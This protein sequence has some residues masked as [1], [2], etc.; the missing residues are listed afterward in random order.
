MTNHIK[1]ALL[2]LLLSFSFASKGQQFVV[3]ESS[4][5]P[6]S[7]GQILNETAL[8]MLD[9]NNELTVISEHGKLIKI[10]GPYKGIIGKEI[11]LNDEK[12]T[13]NKLTTLIDSLSMLLMKNQ[14]ERL[15]A[16]RSL[17]VTFTK[18]KVINAQKKAWA[19]D[20]N[21]S[22]NQCSSSNKTLLWNSNKAASVF[23]K[24]KSE[25]TM[26]TVDLKINDLYS[27]W[28]E[29]IQRKDNNIYQLIVSGDYQVNEITLHLLD[30]QINNEKIN[31]AL[32]MTQQGCHSQAIILLLNIEAD[33]IIEKNVKQ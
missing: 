4:I 19:I 25:D 8:I 7:K 30:L 20:I 11:G 26:V 9:K 16:T 32:W 31:Q 17:D 28:P 27:Q 33:Q 2:T 15:G 21:S 1:L 24:N 18:A 3:L 12:S 5:Q 29:K 10:K 13:G 6:Y 23:I 22:G 14:K